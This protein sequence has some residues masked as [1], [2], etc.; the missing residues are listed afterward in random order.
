[1]GR[2]TRCTYYDFSDF[3]HRHA[4][5]RGPWNQPPLKQF[6]TP[7]DFYHGQQGSDVTMFCHLP[8]PSH[9]Q[10]PKIMSLPD[11]YFGKEGNDVTEWIRYM[12]VARP[13]SRDHYF[14][15]PSSD[16]TQWLNVA[17]PAGPSDEP[18][19]F[20]G[21]TKSYVTDPSCSPNMTP[22]GRPIDGVGT[23]DA[24]TWPATSKIDQV[25]LG[26]S[27]SK[28]QS[29]L[30]ALARSQR[31]PSQIKPRP[32]AT[33]GA[34]KRNSPGYPVGK[35]GKEFP[36]PGW[37]VVAPNF[38][39]TYWGKCKSY[40]TDYAVSPTLTPPGRPLL[41]DQA[42]E[43]MTYLPVTEKPEKIP[44]GRSVKRIGSPRPHSPTIQSPH[45]NDDL[46]SPTRKLRA[47]LHL[48][49][50]PSPPPGSQSPRRSLSVPQ[51]SVGSTSPLPGSQSA[52]LQSASF[53]G[54]KS[55]QASP[56]P[57]AS[58]SGGSAKKGS[59]GNLRDQQK[60]GNVT[61]CFFVVHIF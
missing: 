45:L 43:A 49:P 29:M 38:D 17:V 1:M 16:V 9:A 15:K 30:N 23:M 44:L 11:P 60:T 3:P 19:E 10:D 27:V 59:E 33:G 57:V 14:G 35:S 41:G 56:S 61:W 21:R 51:I 4:Q 37:S 58:S 25:P 34:R 48:T 46:G 40:I 52:P 39:P 54:A 28:F 24:M 26:Q 32:N 50:H 36:P 31:K 6:Q 12:D 53:P 8:P 20:W 5:I 2:K 7:A 42:R 55:V 47:R 18:G 13:A 22:P